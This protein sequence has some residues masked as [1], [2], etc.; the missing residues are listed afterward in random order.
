VIGGCFVAA[1]LHQ[2]IQDIP[3]LIQRPPQVMSLATNRAE[4]KA[5]TPMVSS[6]VSHERPFDPCQWS[7]RASSGI[8]SRLAFSYPYIHT[9]RWA[10]RP[11]QCPRCQSHHI[12]RWGTYQYH[13]GCKRYWCHRCKRTFNDLTDTLLHQSQRPLAYWIRATSL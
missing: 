12:G 5:G 2:N 7:E 1:A 9:L 11:Q 4:I 6:K 13:P 8:V 10:D 3:I